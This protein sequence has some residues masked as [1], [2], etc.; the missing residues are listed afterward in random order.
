M[1]SHYQY[2]KDQ[3][4]Q[5]DRKAQSIRDEIDRLYVELARTQEARLQFQRLNEEVFGEPEQT[6]V[7]QDMRV[8]QGFIDRRIEETKQP[9]IEQL[10]DA[11]GKIQD[12]RDKALQLLHRSRGTDRPKPKKPKRKAVRG[13][14]T[15]RILEHLKGSAEPLTLSE[16][17]LF[18]GI[19]DPDERSR[20]RG[21]LGRLK[22]D[23]VITNPPGEPQ[24]TGNVASYLFVRRNGAQPHA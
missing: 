5:F 9:A 15:I 7:L 8:R 18:H 14:W 16:I 22:K 11:V 6:V 12:Q 20:L 4:Q 2:Y 23:G 24:G 19:T 1:T 13:E 10:R 3:L 17:A 21:A